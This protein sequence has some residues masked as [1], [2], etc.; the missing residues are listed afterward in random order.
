MVEIAAKAIHETTAAAS[1]GPQFW[2]TEARAALAT[3]FNTLGI[4]EKT[5]PT[6]DK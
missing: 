1:D 3:A 4:Q 5:D 2:L 6:S